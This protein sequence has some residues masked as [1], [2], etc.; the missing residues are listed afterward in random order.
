MFDFSNRIRQFKMTHPEGYSGLTNAEIL[1]VFNAWYADNSH[2]NGADVE[3]Q[4]NLH[5]KK[6]K[7]SLNS[8]TQSEGV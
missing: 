5:I 3:H 6:W 1:N 8:K 7:Q 2:L 4:L